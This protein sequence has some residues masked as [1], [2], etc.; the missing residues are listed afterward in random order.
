LAAKLGADFLGLIM[1]KQSPRYVT[2]QVAR[3]II[4]ATIPTVQFVIVSV[5]QSASD[6]ISVADKLRC[7]LVQIHGA[8]T[9]K[10]INTI[11]RA[12]LKVIQAFHVGSR[13]DIDHANKSHAD[14]ILLDNK[15]SD[16]QPTYGGTGRRF[17]WSLL[18]QRSARPRNLIIAGGLS[19]DNFAMAIKETQPLMLDFNS[20]VEAAPG[21]K[22]PAKLKRLFIALEQW[23]CKHVK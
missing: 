23:R 3:D 8:Y 4:K 19:A 12:G 5:D 21:V 14:F 13:E 22:S 11:R 10:E 16:T 18:A 20:G 7:A 9:V 15:L 6:I 2:Q 1:H 17:D